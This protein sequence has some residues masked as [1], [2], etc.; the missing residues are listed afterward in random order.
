[1]EQFNVFKKKHKV[2]PY[3]PQK[4]HAIEE[5]DPVRRVGFCEFYLNQPYDKILPYTEKFY[6]LTSALSQITEFLIAIIIDT[7]HVK[8]PILLSKPIFKGAST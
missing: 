3:I 2:R 6:G 8:T 7:G 4:V 5:G 1:M